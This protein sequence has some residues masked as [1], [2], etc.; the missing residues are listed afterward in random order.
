[1]A[2]VEP[3]DEPVLMLLAECAPVLCL[4]EDLCFCKLFDDELWFKV[5]V[6]FYP[7]IPLLTAELELLCEATEAL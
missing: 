6:D 5:E 7:W 1:M 4:E 2:M 3:K